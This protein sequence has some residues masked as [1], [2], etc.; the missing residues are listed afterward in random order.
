[1]K[2]IVPNLQIPILHDV[3]QCLESIKEVASLSPLLWNVQNKPLLDLCD[4]THPDIIF[5]HVSQLDIAFAMACHEFN[6]QYILI[7][8][9][10]PNNLPRPPVAILSTQEFLHHF[11]KEYNVIQIKNGARVTQIHNAQYD[12]DIECDV[13][14]HTT[15]V[16]LTSQIFDILYF[17]VSRYSTKII[18]ES[19]VSLHHYLGEVTMFEKS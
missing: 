8:E 6:F 14:V 9:G 1:M 19:P 15:D 5:L 13:L 16:N 7:G 2:I 17:L 12:Q 18:G 11:P 3:A 4:E 10:V